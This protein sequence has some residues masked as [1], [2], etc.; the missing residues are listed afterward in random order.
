MRGRQK[1]TQSTKELS[2]RYVTFGQLQQLRNETNYF[3]FFAAGFLA[4]FLA[5]GF[6]AAVLAF[7]IV[8][9][10]IVD[11]VAPGPSLP[12]SKPGQ[13]QCGENQ[14]FLQTEFSGDHYRNNR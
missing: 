4:A 5:A 10:S 9:P 13:A 7:M 1:Q 2:S 8:R 3:F 14:I 12:D 6:L 11:P